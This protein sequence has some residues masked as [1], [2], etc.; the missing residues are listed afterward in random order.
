MGLERF[1]G[2]RSIPH[3]RQT[4]CRVSELGSLTAIEREQWV[5]AAH[6]HRQLH[7]SDDGGATGV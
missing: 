2:D 4:P 5:P 6:A 7:S 1:I 3:H